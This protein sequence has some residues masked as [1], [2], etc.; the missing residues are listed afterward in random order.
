V[1]A[2]TKTFRPVTEDEWRRM[3]WH[4]QQRWL[5]A[6]NALR[7]QLTAEL[8]A[9]GREHRSQLAHRFGLSVAF[10]LVVADGEAYG[11]GRMAAA[12][13]E[14]WPNTAGSRAATA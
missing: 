14:A 5:L 8:E 7:R 6:A 12:E 4:A 2:P 1:T 11:P 10:D 13:S 3:S 9:V